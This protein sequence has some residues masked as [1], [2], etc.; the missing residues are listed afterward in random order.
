M[1][2]NVGQQASHWFFISVCAAQYL[3]TVLY[4]QGTSLSF[5]FLLCKCGQKHDYCIGFIDFLKYNFTY[6]F[7]LAV[8]GL[9]CCSGC[10]L[11]AE[12]RRYSLVAVH[13]LLVAVASL[14]E[15]GL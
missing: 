11:V 5:G 10:C 3:Q 1:G 6:V 14:V 15:H 12:S 7:I 8:L 13:G 4:R 9:R 2:D